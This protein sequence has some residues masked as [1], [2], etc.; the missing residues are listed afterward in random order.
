MYVCMYVY[1]LYVYICRPMYKYVCTST[2]Y[3]IC[4]SVLCVYGLHGLF[5]FNASATARVILR[6]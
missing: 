3:Y 1:I 2:I 5:G 6:R 4:L